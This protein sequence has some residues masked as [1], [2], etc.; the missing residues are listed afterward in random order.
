MPD[1]LCPT[2][3]QKEDTVKTSPDA[4]DAAAESLPVALSPEWPADEPDFE[5]RSSV[6]SQL[7]A[8]LDQAV[9]EVDAVLKQ[10]IRALRSDD[11]RQAA[12]RRELAHEIVI[13]ALLNR[14]N[15]DWD[16]AKPSTHRPLPDDP[17][18]AM[19]AQ[20]NADVDTTAAPLA[21][22]AP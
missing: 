16:P 6:V 2:D 7:M 19:L 13:G 10:S 15:P 12:E 5:E 11:P 17:L 9:M 21:Q 14:E 22:A 18:L 1:C 3:P 8:D 4:T 20:W